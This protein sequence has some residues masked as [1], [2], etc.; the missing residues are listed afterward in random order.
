MKPAAADLTK[1]IASLTLLRFF[2]AE[3][4]ARASIMELLSRM[5]GTVEQLDWLVV[6]MI[7]RVGEWPGPKELRGVFCTRFKP[8]DGIEAWCSLPG[9]T[10]ADSEATHAAMLPA[11][12]VRLLESGEREQLVVSADPAIQQAVERVAHTK[13]L[14][15][16]RKSDKEYV[17]ALWRK[18][19]LCE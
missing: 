1:A 6:T 11:A 3:D 15:A 19:G 12:P 10:A 8:A 13:Q 9:F 4:I 2:P 14:P 16:A 18:A 17:E 7:D 5:I